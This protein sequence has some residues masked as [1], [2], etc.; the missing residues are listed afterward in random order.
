MTVEVDGK[1]AEYYQITMIP[2]NWYQWFDP[3]QPEDGPWI[4]VCK[5]L[6]QHIIIMYVC[7]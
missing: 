3:K 7:V 5:L 1:E 2:A 4:T 6:Y